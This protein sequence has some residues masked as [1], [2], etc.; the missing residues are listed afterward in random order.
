MSRRVSGYYDLAKMFLLNVFDAIKCYR[1]I[2]KM[3]GPI[4]TIFGGKY[5]EENE[6]YT[7]K[8]SE[9]GKKL[10]E[11]GIS[12]ITGGGP[13]IMQAANFGAS[14]RKDGLWSVGVVVKGMPEDLNDCS[15]E[16]LS[17]SSL[18][19]RKWMLMFNSATHI[20]FPGGYG[21][22]DEFFDIKLYNQ[23]EY[24]KDSPIILIGKDYWKPLIK[25]MS[26]F[27]YDKKLVAAGEIPKFLLTDDVDEVIDL[28][29]KKV[30]KIN[31]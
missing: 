19:A 14:T 2:K 18:Y 16:H 9:L 11:H 3:S 26:E 31:E 24:L 17:V 25:W 23:I 8:A 21:T 29:K 28:L 7:K 22:L 27:V 15:Q 12:V 13:G 6:V 20:F 1:T 30:L 4:A 10:V 5:S